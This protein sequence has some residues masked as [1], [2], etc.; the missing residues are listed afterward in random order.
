MSRT[1]P[2][3]TLAALLAAG[4]LRAADPKEALWE[5]ARKGD[6]K[7]VEALIK[8]G[9]D[10]N[11]KTAYGATALSF[12]ADQG[13]REVVRALLKAKADVNAA[14]TFYSA[15]PVMWAVMHD[16]PDIVRDLVAAGAKADGLL[17]TAAALGHTETTR[18]LIEL[19]KP[20]EVSLTNALA[21]VPEDRPGLKELLVKAGAKPKPPP[22][23]DVAKLAPYAGTYKG[24]DAELAVLV[25]RD[26]LVVAAGDRPLYTLATDDGAAFRTVASEATVGFGKQ[27]DKVVR[28]TVKLDGKETVYERFEKPAAPAAV[29]PAE[30]TPGVVTKPLN[31]P[32]FRGPGA[33]GVADGQFP[34]TGWDVATGRNVRWKTPIPGLGH[35]CPVVWGDRVYLATAVGG[36]AAKET[37]RTGQYGDVDSVNDASPHTWKVLAL[38]RK[39]GRIVWDRTACQGVP[40]V[41]RHL[42]AT[43]A[44]STPST[45]GA[46]VVACFGSEGLYCYDQ[47]GN[48]LWRRDLG[49]LDSGW[50][51]NPE[52]Q[53]GFGSSPVLYKDRVIVQCDVGKDSFL[54]AYALADGHTLWQT[55]RDE[56]PSWGSPTVVQG[57]NRVEV[58]TNGT[59]FARGYDPDTGKELWRLARNSEITVPT[60]FLAKGLI[61]VTS[62]YRPVQ[63]IYAVRPGANGDVSLKDKETANASVAWSKTRGGPYLPTPI[64]YGDYLYCCANSGLVTCYEAATGKQLYSE[65]LGGSGGYTASPVA[66]DGRL[67]FTGEDGSVRVVKAGPKF[68]PLA[69]NKL[70]EPCLS[71]PAISDGMLFVRTQHHLFALGR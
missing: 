7:A 17:G 56:V 14:D 40:K 34:P 4:T 61:F 26:Q 38:D 36:D 69:T 30:E 62:G 50:F 19:T 6:A 45:D 44:N 22:K 20:S 52:Y 66:A 33:T 53:W 21:A 8:Q 41:K 47:G 57:P 48:L 23:F 5:A 54:A 11:A 71:T 39:T 9:V 58:V 70:G 3:L 49:T 37:L 64:V 10:V 24:P 42:K 32:S 59:K 12:A 29:A 18:V 31:W 60:P 27:G 63:P 2:C 43:Q 13:H 35:S 25:R 1:V 67:Y 16:H 65:R 68:E 55:P 46:H 15:T 51:Y 28:L